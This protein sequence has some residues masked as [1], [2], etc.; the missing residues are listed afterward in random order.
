M[1]SKN[2]KQTNAIALV[3][4]WRALTPTQQLA[5]LDA[6][7][8]P[9]VGAKRQRLKLSAIINPVT[10]TP[11]PEAVFAVNVELANVPKKKKFKKGAK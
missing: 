4:A 7:L 11:A 2:Q 8:G 10:P 6:R 1:Q 3:N 9:G 5:S